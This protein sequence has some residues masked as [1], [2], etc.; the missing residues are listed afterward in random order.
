VSK[1][2]KQI[3][4]LPKEVDPSQDG[5]EWSR[6]GRYLFYASR[7]NGIQ[8]I[9]KASIPDGPLIQV[10]TGAGDGFDPLPSHQE[11]GLMY[12]SGRSE[13]GLWLIRS[14][15]KEPEELIGGGWFSD[16]ILS[17]DGKWLAYLKEAP[18]GSEAG[19]LW[20]MELGSP[21]RHR[22]TEGDNCW[23][24][25]WSQD[26]KHLAYS[27]LMGLIDQK[28]YRLFVTEFPEVAPREITHGDF[29]DFVQDWGPENKTILFSRA[30]GGKYS[31]ES[32]SLS[33]LVVSPVAENFDSGS[34]SA[35]GNWILALPTTEQ[36]EQK[37][38]WL[39]RNSGGAGSRISS[40][41]TRNA[42][43]ANKDEA[44]IY[45]R[46]GK[47]SAVVELW[48]LQFRD[49][50]IVGAPSLFTTFPASAGAKEDWDTSD[51]LSV[52]VYPRKIS[53]ASFYQS[54]S[55]N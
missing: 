52:I 24:A 42:K 40:V 10:T 6:D 2:G 30:I 4:K 34:Y 5:V 33:T 32:I 37:G 44:V 47:R 1:D 13:R 38:I 49:G 9:W 15:R 43:W 21:N 7:K 12:A 31:L 36:P 45:N 19:T 28:R 29:D 35:D 14:S 55:H 50:K 54:I 11:S 8:N 16:P 22:I 20:T 53:Q 25:V 51:D 26:G 39:F 23:Q 41:D 27:A 48:K 3:I 18:G 46:S 17:H